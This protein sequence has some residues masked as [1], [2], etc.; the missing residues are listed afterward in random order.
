MAGTWDE[1]QNLGHRYLTALSSFATREESLDA[2]ALFPFPAFEYLVLASS[3]QCT[4]I[5][6]L[7][8][9]VQSAADLQQLVLHG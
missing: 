3:V 1:P 7:T 4:K 2:A 9:F 6:L 5:Y 8:L